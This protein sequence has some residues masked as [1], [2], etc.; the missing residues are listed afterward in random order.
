MHAIVHAA[1]VLSG[2]ATT[3]RPSHIAPNDI[4]DSQFNLVVTNP[5]L[6]QVNW[7]D[8][9]LESLRATQ[10]LHHSVASIF[11]PD[12]LRKTAASAALDQTI[13]TP[14]TTLSDQELNRRQHRGAFVRSGPAA[15]FITEQDDT[16]LLEHEPR[17]QKLTKP[18]VLIEGTDLLPL[19]DQLY[20]TH[21]N[22]PLL[23]L[24]G[25]QSEPQS[26]QNLLRLIQGHTLPKRKGQRFP[27]TVRVAL[28]MEAKEKTIIS[29]LQSPEDAYL[30]EECVLLNSRVTTAG[31]NHPIKNLFEEDCRGFSFTTAFE[32]AVAST[33]SRRYQWKQDPEKGGE[34]L[35]IG[36]TQHHKFLDWLKSDLAPIGAD[37]TGHRMLYLSIF[38]LL[39]E[40][41][42]SS[43]ETVKKHQFHLLSFELARLAITESANEKN[44]L[45]ELARRSILL[46]DCLRLL[47]KL[48]TSNGLS[49]RDIQRK[50]N[51]LSRAQLLP[52]LETL[53]NMELITILNGLVYLA[54]DDAEDAL[55]ANL[56]IAGAPTLQ[57]HQHQT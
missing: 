50:Y 26:A 43:V 3:G 48:S 46:P 22:A 39:V 11:D 36:K 38:H 32:K 29:W 34:I 14:V 13:D 54:V 55:I 52:L 56:S 44:R 16:E 1:C 8:E 33:L 31:S 27:I 42:N 23:Y 49:P 5:Q 24:R 19:S 15:G 6:R 17:L 51:K 20:E 18:T 28:L 10:A 30:A 47:S 4:A 12:L 40:I 35:A 57:E 21:L 37:C 53:Q 9:W 25:H 41:A 45:R 7:M 2:I